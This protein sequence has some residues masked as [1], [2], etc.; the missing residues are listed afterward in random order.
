MSTCDTSFRGGVKIDRKLFSLVGKYFH[1]VATNTCYVTDQEPT[2]E[3]FRQMSKKEVRKQ[4][5]SGWMELARYETLVLA[6]DALLESP[7]VRQFT[8]E[9][10]ANQ[11]GTT[12]KSL[13]NRIDS[14]IELSL[15]ETDERDGTTVYSLND[16]SPIVEKLYEL[17]VTVQRVRDGSGIDPEESATREPDGHTGFPDDYLNKTGQGSGSYGPELQMPE[18]E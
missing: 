8:L 18:G 9:E 14:L 11:A 1:P 5:P 13:R 15:V 16:E 10:L 6:L 7:A 2:T 12:P 17:N 3:Q 4:F